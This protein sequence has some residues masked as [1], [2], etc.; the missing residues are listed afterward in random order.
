MIQHL[1]VNK[2]ERYS[3]FKHFEKYTCLF[4]KLPVDIN[5]NMKES[6]GFINENGFALILN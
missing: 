1:I 5:I 6:K 4:I 3:I 2:R